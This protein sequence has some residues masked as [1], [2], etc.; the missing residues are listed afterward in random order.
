MYGKTKTCG[1]GHLEFS[2]HRKIFVKDLPRNI[3]A[4]FHFKWFSSLR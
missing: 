3:P 4:R 1:G 2:N